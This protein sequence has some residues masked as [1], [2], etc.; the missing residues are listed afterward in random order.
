[1]KIIILGAGQV[2][3]STAES[4]VNEGNDVTVVD[5]DS[6]LLERIQDRLDIRAVNGHASSPETLIAAGIEDADMLIAVT[7]NDEV[8]MVACQVA[9]AL[10]KTPK[11][12]ARIRASDYVEYPALFSPDAFATDVIIS[13]EQL[14]T[15]YIQ[16]LIEQP[17]VLQV[18]EFFD[19]MAQLV[20]VEVSEQSPMAGKPISKLLD[21]LPDIKMRVA[22]IFRDNQAIQATG[23]EALQPGDEI[24]FLAL[25]Q[26]ISKL[27]KVFRHAYKTYERI[28]IAG[29]GNIGRQLAK[30][31]ETNHKV[32]IIEMDPKRARFIAEGLKK[33]V[34]LHGDAG[35]ANLLQEENISKT[36][37]FCAVT[38]DDEVN[39][40]SSML[41]KRMGAR[42][43]ISIIGKASHVELVR[44]TSI[45]LAISPAQI[46]I[47]SLLT[48]IRKGDVV[49]VHSLRQGAAEAIEV[50]AHG[51][52]TTSKV[53]GRHIEQI[54][55]P[56]SASVAAILRNE[57]VLF[58]DKSLVIEPD[59]HLIIFIS[60]QRDIM[61]VEKL[62]QVDFNYPM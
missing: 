23:R 30:R 38:N 24:F 44:G 49:T 43:V 35:D 39:I 56:A 45:D 58:S 27:V 25:T 10:F 57:H 28:L 59:D 61:A 31:I 9:N 8:N 42:K 2:G 55:L 22:A 7:Q 34:V 20:A 29:G 52:L 51:D 3:G 17:E 12:L 40:L 53:V 6:Y 26:H 4:L 60:N 13:P 32:K 5:T 19:G 50:I 47:G 48:H 18:V 37:V 46:T 16:R 21:I 33:S 15:A 11:K 41:A 14:V 36:D 62:F 54:K 1:M